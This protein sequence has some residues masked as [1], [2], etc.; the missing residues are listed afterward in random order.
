MVIRSIPPE[1][2]PSSISQQSYEDLI[3]NVNLVMDYEHIPWELVPVAKRLNLKW[4]SFTDYEIPSWVDAWDKCYSS[5]TLLRA[6][7]G[8]LKNA[9]SANDNAG[10]DALG[11]YW[12][13]KVE[14]YMSN[15]S[16]SALEIQSALVVAGMRVVNYKKITLTTMQGLYEK[17]HSWFHKPS[18]KDYEVNGE[19]LS[20]QLAS[21]NEAIADCTRRVNDANGALEN[22]KSKLTADLGAFQAKGVNTWGPDRK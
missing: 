9:L 11:D 18:D 13:D 5:S 3:G 2:Q 15:T 1:P 6:A 19:N 8:A 21:V 17:E 7:R 4:P 10:V 16:R 12:N 22:V 20:R 14:S